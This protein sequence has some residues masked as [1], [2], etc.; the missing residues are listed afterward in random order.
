MSSSIFT[1]E[2][3]VHQHLLVIRGQ[4]QKLVHQF[5]ALPRHAARHARQHLTSVFSQKFGWPDDALR[6]SAAEDRQQVM[7]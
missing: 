6:T 7:T 3:L 4:V 2:F 1:I 5:A